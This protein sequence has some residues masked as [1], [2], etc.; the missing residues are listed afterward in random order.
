MN[1][2]API[3]QTLEAL[4][5]TPLSFLEHFLR[6]RPS[7]A[8]KVWADFVYDHPNNP[9]CLANASWL[10]QTMEDHARNLLED[11]SYVLIIVA[12]LEVI[13][14]WMVSQGIGKPINRER[15][16]EGLYVDYSIVNTRQVWFGVW[17]GV[18]TRSLKRAKRWVCKK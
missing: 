9:A 5:L 17:A 3:Q 16:P 14:E 11:T 10:C 2:L 18:I 6:A 4:K 7:N 13:L 15:I 1:Q 12:P 8:C